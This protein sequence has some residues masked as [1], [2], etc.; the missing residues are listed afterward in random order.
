MNSISV[1]DL[2]N[3][4]DPIII[5]IRDSQKY[6]DNHINGARNIVYEQLMIYPYKY[7]D[8]NNKYYLYCQKGIKSRR[9][10]I[11]RNIK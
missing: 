11:K 8:K 7:L 2:K 10:C 1:L 4:K 5:D 3:I 6:N 9:L